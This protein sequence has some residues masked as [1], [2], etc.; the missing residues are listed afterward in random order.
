MLLYCKNSRCLEKINYHG[1]KKNSGDRIT[2]P[3]CHYRY[4]LWKMKIKPEISD[5][6]DKPKVTHIPPEQKNAKSISPQGF[7]LSKRSFQTE[8]C[9]GRELSIQNCSEEIFT[10]MNDFNMA[11][12]RDK[13]VGKAKLSKQLDQ[14]E[15]IKLCKEH[16]LPAIYESSS[17]KWKCTK[18]YA[19]EFSKIRSFS[20]TNNERGQTHSP[21]IVPETNLTSKQKSESNSQESSEISMTNKERLGNIDSLHF[22]TPDDDP[23][24][25]ILDDQGNIKLKELI[26]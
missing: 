16:N 12:L 15:I 13:A 23:E 9:S 24:V 21:C 18:C 7:D 2:C 4:P 26:G 25:I 1:K 10:N 6:L 5:S 17:K 11:L 19:L 14:D 8:E 20:D 3:K 22:Q